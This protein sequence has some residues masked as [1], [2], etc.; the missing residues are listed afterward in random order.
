MIAMV[1]GGRWSVRN[2][3]LVAPL[4]QLTFLLAV[5]V[6]CPLLTSSESYRIKDT[7][8]LQITVYI[9]SAST[10]YNVIHAYYNANE[11]GSSMYR[12]AA[13]ASTAKATSIQSS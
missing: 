8:T 4:Q 6:K 2:N 9:L 5:F 12:C 10:G 7:S 1:V 11:G 13:V 3:F